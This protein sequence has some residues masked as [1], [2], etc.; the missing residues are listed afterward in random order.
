MAVCQT[1]GLYVVWLGVA[2]CQLSQD[3]FCVGVVAALH[4]LDQRASGR[5][6]KEGNEAVFDKA[7]SAEQIGTVRHDASGRETFCSTHPWF[8]RR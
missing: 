4:E 8:E 3:L 5:Q 6:Y 1:D 7:R 2:S